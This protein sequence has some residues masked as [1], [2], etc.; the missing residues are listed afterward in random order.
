MSSLVWVFGGKM[1][2]SSHLVAAW[3]PVFRGVKVRD[4]EDLIQDIHS[5]QWSFT[6]NHRIK[7]IVHISHFSMSLLPAL[8]DWGVQFARCTR[9]PLYLWLYK[10]EFVFPKI[11]HQMQQLLYSVCRW[12]HD[13]RAR[14]QQQQPEIGCVVDAASSLLTFIAISKDLSISYQVCGQWWPCAA[15]EEILS[16]LE[17][18]TH[19][20]RSKSE[21]EVRRKWKEKWVS[22]VLLLLFE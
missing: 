7:R 20:V 15:R 18:K 11:H 14:I 4:L 8:H 1:L 2:V 12:E 9:F 10:N 5:S 13:P 3:R 6:Q 17:R 22:S 19:F 21:L 16:P